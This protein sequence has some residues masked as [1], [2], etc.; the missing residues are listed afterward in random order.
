MLRLAQA[1]LDFLQPEPW[2]L[3]TF[4]GR[5]RTLAKAMQRG[6]LLLSDKGVQVLAK[7]GRVPHSVGA[8]APP[9][10]RPP[11]VVTCQACIEHVVAKLL[12]GA[13]T[14]PCTVRWSLEESQGDAAWPVAVKC[15]LSVMELQDAWLLAFSGPVPHVAAP[16]HVRDEA[17]GMWRAGGFFYD[18]EAHL[19]TGE[20][21]RMRG[22]RLPR[23][24]QQHWYYDGPLQSFARSGAYSLADAISSEHTLHV[25]HHVLVSKADSPR[26]TT[27]PRF[28]EVRAALCD[29][30]VRVH[31]GE[32]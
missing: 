32:L 22:G 14:A 27:S 24:Y 5:N 28:K 17:A 8:G 9:A 30:A 21:V 7:A 29:F 31:F 16:T 3:L 10:C 20:S 23:P 12:P 19:A 2:E 26:T 6:V 13:T 15:T 4:H 1:L 18:L 25:L 11:I